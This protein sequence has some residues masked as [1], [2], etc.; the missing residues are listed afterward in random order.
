MCADGVHPAQSAPLNPLPLMEVLFEFIGIDL[1]GPFHPSACGYPF[2]LV[3]VDYATWYTCATV[4]HFCDEFGGVLS[5][6]PNWHPKRDADWPGHIVHVLHNKSTDYWVLNVFGSAPTTLRLRQIHDSFIHKD[7]HNCDQVTL[8][9][10]SILCGH[11]ASGGHWLWESMVGQ[12][13]SHTQPP[14]RMERDWNSSLVALMK[15]RDESGPEVPN[16]TIPSLLQHYS[17]F[18]NAGFNQGLL[19]DSIVCRIQ[20]K[21]WPFPVCGGCTRLSYFI[22]ACLER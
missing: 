3:L 11:T 20:G 4:H 16:S 6:P 19:A 15:E 12:G 1:I 14:K 13:R 7:E 8:Q 17:F 2:L 18:H 10:A 22:L 21:K 9:V 5:H